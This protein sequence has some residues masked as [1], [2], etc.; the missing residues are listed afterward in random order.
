MVRERER[1]IKGERESIVRGP[2]TGF[3]SLQ[4]KTLSWKKAPEALRRL[5]VDATNFK[6]VK[7]NKKRMNLQCKE[8]FKKTYLLKNLFDFCKGILFCL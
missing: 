3:R 8:N 1:E 5:F 6:N 7:K 2:P 4:E